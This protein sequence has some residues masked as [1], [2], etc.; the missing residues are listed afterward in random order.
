MRRCLLDYPDAQIIAT[1][2]THSANF[3][4][5]QVTWVKLD[6]T[7]EQDIE[8]LAGTI[9]QLDILVNTIGFLHSLNEK[10]EKT[11]K[12][13]E[14]AFFEKNIRLNTLPSLLLAKHFMQSLQSETITYFVVLSARVGSI[15]DNRVGGWLS[16][17]A[18]KSALNMAMKTISIEWKRALPNCCVL[19]FHPGT[20]DT[21]LSKPFQRNLPDGQL[22]SAEA[23][24]KAL[25]ALIKRSGPADSG[26]FVSFDE[27]EIGW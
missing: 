4:H 14:Q 3:E 6:A 19:L 23:T 26:K 11:I 10:P 7:V 22:H 16:Y 15:S 8:R 20:T 17:R 21:D 27:A 1:Y 12:N 5:P 18:S 9:G 2:N 25:L 24:A 13:F